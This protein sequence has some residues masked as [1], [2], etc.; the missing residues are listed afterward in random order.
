MKIHIVNYELGFNDG[1]LS[2]FANK[3]YE[4]LKKIDGLEVT[5]SKTPNLEADINHH[6]NYLPYKHNPEYK[7]IDTLMV[8]HIFEGYKKDALTEQMKTAFGICV[9]ND[10]KKQLVKWGF[11]KKKLT[12]VLPAHDGI[13][14]RFQ[15]VAIL[16][17]VYADGCKRE[18][19]FTKLVETIDLNKWAFRI[20]GSGWKDILVPL[21]AKGL[22]VDYY[23]QFEPSIHQKILESS[24]YNLYMGIDDGSMAVLDSKNAGLKIIAPNVGFNIDVGV[25]YPF[26]NQEE[27]N[28]IFQKLTYNP[29]ADW[30]WDNYAKQHFKLW[31]KLKK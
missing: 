20:M 10:T 13:P 14:R 18:E 12:T 24:D 6:V 22:Q 11:D 7:G 8:T 29:V 31:K 19:M 27:L 21:V 28:A 15:V 5:I 23:A 9:S 30:T 17:N 1:I 25:D 16:T 26:K 4:E 3:L 2:K